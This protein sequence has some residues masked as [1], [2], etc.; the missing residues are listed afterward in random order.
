MEGRETWKANE[1]GRM[2]GGRKGKKEGRG[3][4]GGREGAMRKDGNEAMGVH[5]L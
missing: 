1:K 2:Q 5:A 4:E 3:R